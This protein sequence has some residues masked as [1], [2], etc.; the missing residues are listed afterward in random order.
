[1][2]F[3]LPPKQL[4][5]GDYLVYFGLLY[6]DIRQLEILSNEGLDFVKTKAKETALSSFRQYN[7][8]LPQNL[9]KGELEALTY[10]SKNKIS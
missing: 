9:S 10:R 8:N 4:K 1:M 2:N 3:C 6:R 5:Y 7:K